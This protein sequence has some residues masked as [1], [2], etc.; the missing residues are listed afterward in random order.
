MMGIIR[1]RLGEY[2]SMEYRYIS[3][4]RMDY[5]RSQQQHTGTEMTFPT[6]IDPLGGPIIREAD[7]LWPD[8]RNLGRPSRPRS[9]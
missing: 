1:T 2:G 5:F 6:V 3:K 9:D 7:W 4:R 8:Q